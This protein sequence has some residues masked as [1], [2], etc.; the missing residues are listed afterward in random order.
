MVIHILDVVRYCNANYFGCPN[1]VFVMVG[2]VILWK[3]DIQAL[4]TSLT[5]E[6]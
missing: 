4:I 5:M 2:R 6:I 3:S 1:C